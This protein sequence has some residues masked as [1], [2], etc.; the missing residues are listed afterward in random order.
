[1]EA[2]RSDHEV[3]TELAGLK[4]LTWDKDGKVVMNADGKPVLT[5]LKAPP[6]MRQLMSHTAGFGY[7]LSGDDP[8]NNAFRTERVLASENLDVMMKKLAGI[9]LLYEPGTKWSYSVAVDIQGYLVQK[10]SGKSSATTSRRT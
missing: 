1:M 9:P 8:V 10:L 3:R 5:T 6:T 7:G 2:R 4:A